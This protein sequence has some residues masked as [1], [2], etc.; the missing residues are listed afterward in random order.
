MTEKLKQVLKHLVDF[1][2]QEL[3]IITECFKPKSIKRNASL[4]LQ[5][6]VCSEFYFVHSGCIRTGFLTKDGIEKTRYV[7]PDNYIGTALTSF[8]SQQPSFEFVD[9]Q[10]DSELLVISHS[11]F[12]KLNQE[13]ASWKV[14]YQRILEMAYAFQNKKIEGLVTLTAKQRYELLLRED[15]ILTQ[16]LSNRV[17]ASYLDMSQETL[18]RL[19]SK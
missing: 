6:E 1:N 18:S 12:F 17:L 11:D 3:Q 14:F 19:K 5:G 10:E 8:I 7:M 13:L 16:K 2:E 4:L 15:A 9:A